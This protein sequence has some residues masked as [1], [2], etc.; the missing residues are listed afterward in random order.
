ML[1]W[2]YAQQ[3]DTY[4]QHT[5]NRLSINLIETQESKLVHA[6]RT[7]AWRR[8]GDRKFISTDSSDS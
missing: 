8:E 4:L 7:M 5:D 3:Q 1:Q 2:E 6:L